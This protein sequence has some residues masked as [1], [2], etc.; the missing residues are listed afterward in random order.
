MRR[1]VRQTRLAP[2]L[3]AARLK[4]RIALAVTLSFA[5]PGFA[6]ELG[7]M[8]AYIDGEERVWYTITFQQSGNP[9][10]TATLERKQ[11]QV[12]LLL[13]GHPIRTFTSKEVLSVDARFAGDYAPGDA[14]LSVE[15][16]YTPNGLSGPLWTSRGA[17]TAPQL[18]I[19]D[20][21]AWGGAGR[22]TAVVSGEICRR[23]RLFSQ[24]DRSDCKSV[25]G[26]IDTRL[27]VR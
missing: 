4:M 1:R 6:D 17:P 23:A 7:Q 11:Y 21:Q 16:L 3:H 10:Y 5:S 2:A 15:I 13:Q 19:I 9:V 24:T 8:T 26:M 25:S 18:Q 22:V 12:E 14:P 20:M 27:D